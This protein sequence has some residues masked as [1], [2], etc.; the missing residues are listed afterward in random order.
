MHPVSRGQRDIRFPHG[1]ACV[2]R[3]AHRRGKKLIC[4]VLLKKAPLPR[5]QGFRAKNPALR[6][7]ASSAR[8]R[9]P[10]QQKFPCRWRLDGV[11]DS[12][13]CCP[14]RC[15]AASQRGIG[16]SGE[17]RSADGPS[18]KTG[19]AFLQMASPCNPT[20]GKPPVC[21][22]QTGGFLFYGH[23]PS[24]REAFCMRVR[25]LRRTSAG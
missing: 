11:R 23:R 8:Q 13:G 20:H 4:G 15:P 7:S 10:R 16:N 9:V 6:R 1:S 24:C 5:R 22:G 17:F 14:G 18:G 19:G 12:E 21:T 25:R 2:W 3:P